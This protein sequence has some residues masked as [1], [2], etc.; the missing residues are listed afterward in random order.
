M[1]KILFV[2]QMFLQHLLLSC[3]ILFSRFQASKNDL[4]GGKSLFN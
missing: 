1:N 3:E 2:F 4:I